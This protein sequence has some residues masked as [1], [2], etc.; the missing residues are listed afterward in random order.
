[1]VGE[2]WRSASVSGAV[3]VSRVAG[4]VRRQWRLASKHAR[5][6]YR[7]HWERQ[8]L[9]A[10]RGS[11]RSFTPRRLCAGC[12]EQA[13]IEHRISTLQKQ[14]AK[15]PV[16]HLKA[17]PNSLPSVEEAWNLPIPAELTSRQNQQHQVR[18]RAPRELGTHFARRLPRADASRLPLGAT[19]ALM[20]LSA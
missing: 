5:V 6:E 3:V 20:Q 17:A 2:V 7:V 14:L 4:T 10:A 19:A 9:R 11:Y 8:C 13:A 15:I 16:Q 1:M 12:A 18:E